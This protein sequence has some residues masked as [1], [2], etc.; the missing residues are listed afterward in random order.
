MLEWNSVHAAERGLLTGERALSS[1][2]SMVSSNLERK[3]ALSLNM[4][5][6][7]AISLALSS[8]RMF[9]MEKGSFSDWAFSKKPSTVCVAIGDHIAV[10]DM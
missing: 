10:L 1:K 4:L 5:P 9:E 8:G 3:Q 7:S 6:S 2:A